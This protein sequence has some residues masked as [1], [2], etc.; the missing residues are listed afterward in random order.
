MALDS[1]NN[2]HLVFAGANGLMYYASRE[3]SNWKIQGVIQGGSPSSFVLDSD[4]NPH[5]LYKG[6]NGVMYYAS[7]QGSNWI[8]QTV[9]TGNGYSLAL[10]SQGNPHL[11]YLVSNSLNPNIEELTYASWNGS[12]WSTQTVDPQASDIG[13]NAGVYLELNSNNNPVIMYGYNP[14]GSFSS[15]VKFAT[16]TGSSWSIQTAFY[17]LSNV[18]NLVLASNG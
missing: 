12:N 18:G 7:L 14:G 5:I 9:P 2:P 4:N 8:F 17:N 1:N 6:A 13:S 3:G 16:W 10:D 11:A 15:A